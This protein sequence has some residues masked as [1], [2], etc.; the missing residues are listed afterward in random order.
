VEVSKTYRAIFTNYTLSLRELQ[1]N[2][3]A[4]DETINDEL[5]QSEIASIIW[6]LAE[7][8]LLSPREKVTLQLIEWITLYFGCKLCSIYST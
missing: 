7:I 8:F 3:V 6:H 5:Y 2:S 4:E 1:A